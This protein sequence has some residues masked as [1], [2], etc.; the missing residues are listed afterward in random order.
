MRHNPIRQLAARICRTL[1]RKA[2]D[3]LQDGLGGDVRPPRGT[4]DLQCR[5]AGG[6]E[7]A[8][9]RRLNHTV[10]ATG[11]SVS[12]ANWLEIIPPDLTSELPDLALNGLGSPSDRQEALRLCAVDWAIEAIV[13]PHRWN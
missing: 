9:A 4:D 12:L 2:S 11:N 8:V 7:R 1:S 13:A 5:A 10:R 6:G 3:H